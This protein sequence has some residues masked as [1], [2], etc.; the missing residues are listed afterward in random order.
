MA[1]ITSSANPMCCV[2]RESCD[3][4]EKALM[5]C[6]PKAIDLDNDGIQGSLPV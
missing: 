5:L 6:R 2:V 1:Y 4:C 3:E